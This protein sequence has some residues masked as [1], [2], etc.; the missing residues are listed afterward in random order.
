MGWQDDSSPVPDWQSQSTPVDAAPAAPTQGGFV[1]GRV[2]GYQV[3]GLASVH[4]FLNAMG[5]TAT[6]GLPDTVIAGIHKLTGAGPTGE[7]ARADT[8]A[9][10]NAIGPYASMGADL[11]GYGVGGGSAG[12]GKALLGLTGRDVGGRMAAGAIEGG[13]NAL[14][15]SLGHG[16]TDP[17]SLGKSLI[18]G[19]ITG[20]LTGGLPAAHD[21]P[22][23]RG[24]PDL[25]NDAHDAWA[26]TYGASVQ[27][28][29]VTSA[30]AR[31]HLSL[32]PGEQGLITPSTLAVINRQ[33]EIAGKSPKLT[34]N[35][36][37]KFQDAI[38]GSTRDERE[39]KV[40]GKFRDALDSAYGPQAQWAVASANM[41]TR[42]AK[43]SGELS[44]LKLN[45][46]GAPAAV[47]NMLEKNP[48]FYSHIRST[49]DPIAAM[50]NPTLGQDIKNRLIAAGIGAA[51]GAAL[52]TVVGGNPMGEAAAGAALGALKSRGTASIK[53][54]PIINSILAA[55]HQNATGDR[56]P[57]S[58]FSPSNPYATIPSDL[59]RKLGYAEGA[60]GKY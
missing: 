56:F 20:G 43:T 54:K 13:G 18:G 41:A 7:Q 59:L 60:A 51:G 24:T 53:N 11:L 34:G 21:V 55:K 17:E 26:K 15:G 32:T 19:T 3:P 45:P 44:D 31:T 58:A 23:T 25:M 12:V 22:Q 29:D 37:K 14:A 38:M 28:R 42:R 48:G 40:V 35:D 1:P 16:D 27:P 8:Q 46:K 39:L 30:I 4:N 57:P 10:R 5:D 52:S 33:A 50:S 6:Y 36:L 2:G 9:S 49:L 47:T